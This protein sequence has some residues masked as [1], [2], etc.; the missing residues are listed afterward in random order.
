M[1]W[2]FNLCLAL[3]VLLSVLMGA[4]EIYTFT[5]NLN[6]PPR[7]PQPSIYERFEARCRAAGNCTYQVPGKLPGTLATV[8]TIDGF[9]F[10]IPQAYLG[11][12]FHPQPAT[13]GARMSLWLPSMEPLSEEERHQ[14]PDGADKWRQHLA[15]T[16]KLN[17]KTPHPVTSQTLEQKIIS[18]RSAPQSIPGI[19]SLQE[20][21]R[22]EKMS[23]YRGTD[24]RIRYANGLPTFF[25]CFGDAMAYGYALSSKPNL[26]CVM[27]MT[28]PSGGG[29]EVDINFDRRNHC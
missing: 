4:S 22:K 17:P 26:R 7:L 5:R 6:R 12:T 19:P 16:F 13:D 25:F 1:K 28:W 15:I 11:A 9:H 20:Y 23:F 27:S 14:R 24:N 21:V 29:F 18:S 2:M 8:F 10:E 3:A